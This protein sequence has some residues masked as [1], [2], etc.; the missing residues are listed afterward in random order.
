MGRIS[1]FHLK[2]VNKP[3]IG[4]TTVNDGHRAVQKGML[5]G[6]GGG[7]ESQKGQRTMRL[8]EA[9]AGIQILDRS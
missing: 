3:R 4:Q 6:G 7:G 9:P 2:S 1:L 8:S 5:N